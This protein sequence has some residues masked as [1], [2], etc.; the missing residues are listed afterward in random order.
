MANA[1]VGNANQDFAFF[2][3]CDINLNNF[4]RLTRPK[5]NSST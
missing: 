4:E 3:R 1:G 2:W 5:R